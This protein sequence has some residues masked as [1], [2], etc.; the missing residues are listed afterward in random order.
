MHKNSI[1]KGKFF[2]APVMPKVPEKPKVETMKTEAISQ[3]S[4]SHRNTG[5]VE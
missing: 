3:S 5:T 4:A 1:L 2:K